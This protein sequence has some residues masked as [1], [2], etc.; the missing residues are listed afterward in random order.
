MDLFSKGGPIPLRRNSNDDL[1]HRNV[2]GFE[3]GIAGDN[4]SVPSNLNLPKGYD[5][6]SLK[7]SFEYSMNPENLHEYREFSRVGLW[8]P[9]VDQSIPNVW[10]EHLHPVNERT[11]LM[12]NVEDWNFGKEAELYLRRTGEIDSDVTL[13]LCLWA[14]PFF[15]AG[16]GLKTCEMRISL[17]GFN[18]TEGRWE[19]I[20]KNIIRFN[21]KEDSPRY[22][23][24]YPMNMWSGWGVFKNNG[25][26]NS[27]HPK[28]IM[29]LKCLQHGV[30]DKFKHKDGIT[31]AYIGTDTTEN[32]RSVIRYLQHL[33]PSKI[34]KLTVYFTGEWDTPLLKQIRGIHPLNDNMD[35]ENLKFELKELTDADDGSDVESHDI[36][37]CTYV[38]PWIEKED[39]PKHKA[40]IDRLLD[41]EN[42]ILLTIDPKSSDSL[43]RS[44]T[45][46][47]INTQ[48]T[49]VE[50]L[51]LRSNTVPNANCLI[52]DGL[53]WRK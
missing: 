41:D 52:S 11:E 2:N 3:V 30:E 19:Q 45:S 43:V 6:F 50:D 20:K 18:R 31:V 49:Y 25:T 9:I 47:R 40:R 22:D 1:H 24:Y 10:G 29:T 33:K 23:S 17:K 37:I 39:L 53:I 34:E 36:T 35:L 13:D 51:K 15:N 16:S 32:L 46:Q 14:V 21:L 38:T 4:W 12:L 8:V 5:Q 48:E 28:Q 44:A 42:S 26:G 7:T 27:I